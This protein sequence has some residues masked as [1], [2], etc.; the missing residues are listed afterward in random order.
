MFPPMSLFRVFPLSPKRARRVLFA[1][2]VGAA[3]SRQVAAP[4]D[5]AGIEYTR[6]TVIGTTDL[7]GHIY[8]VDYYT[9][10]PAQ[11]GLAKVA[12]LVADARLGA[13]KLILIDSGDTI[14]GTPLEYYHN[15]V[16]NAPPDPMMLAMNALHYDAMA[17][18]NHDYNFGIQVREKAR[19]EAAFPWLSA[20]TYKA[21]TDENAFQPYLMKEVNGVRVG[22]LGLT[23]PAIP[24][25]ENAPNY[26]GLEFRDPVAEAKKWAGILRTR[27][28]ADVVVVAMHMGLELD[29]ATGEAPPLQLAN[30][31]AG[32]A[33]ARDAPGIDLILLGHTHRDVPSVTIHG[34]LLTQAGRWGDRIAR[35]DLFLKRPWVENG[36]CGRS[37]PR[38]F[39]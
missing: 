19:H 23:T 26:A 29:L 36:G 22:V 21:G 15:R 37:R 31:N 25:W 13:P 35:A 10:R 34:V 4:A 27:E 6:V 8:P 11:L 12:T 39:R 30:E 3:I 2:F 28:R 9:N 18:G 16:E 38:P 33:V 14:Q 5:G 20:N 24:S 1:A 32:I 7:H 17:V